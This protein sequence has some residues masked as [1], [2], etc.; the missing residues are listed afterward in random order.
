MLDF[1]EGWRC[2]ALAIADALGFDH[3]EDMGVWF[4]VIAVTLV[5][6][7]LIILYIISVFDPSLKF[8]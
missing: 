3:A 6:F 7:V 2:L 1:I 5:F 8:W 4:F